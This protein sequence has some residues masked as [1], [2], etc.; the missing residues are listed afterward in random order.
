MSLSKLKQVAVSL[1][2]VG[3]LTACGSNTDKI[4][5]TIATQVQTDEAVVVQLQE[6]MTQQADFM[7][8]FED[9]LKDAAKKYEKVEDVLADMKTEAG[10]LKT[11]FETAQGSL[12]LSESDEEKLSKLLAKSE[13]EERY[14]TVSALVS[15][16]QTY[17]T[18]LEKLSADNAELMTTYE[19]FLGEISGDMPFQTLENL[20]GNLNESLTKVQATYEAYTDSATQFQTL[21]MQTQN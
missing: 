4:I 14:E 21:L 19:S 20:I 3:V 7:E 2:A 16:Y 5:E 17:K 13:K 10:A 11:A 18:N 6:T 15:A 8:A 9:L 1:M 12:V